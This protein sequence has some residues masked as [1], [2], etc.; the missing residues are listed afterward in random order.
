MNRFDGFVGSKTAKSIRGI[1]LK[2]FMM[3]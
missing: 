3:A 2:H 1:F